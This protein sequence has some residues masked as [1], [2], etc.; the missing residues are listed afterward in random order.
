MTCYVE[1]N[2]KSCGGLITPKPL[3]SRYR[4]SLGDT[5]PTHKNMR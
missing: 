1:E 5:T 4:R 2:L 3:W